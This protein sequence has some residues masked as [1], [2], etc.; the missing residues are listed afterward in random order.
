MRLKLKLSSKPLRIKDQQNIFARLINST[1]NKC[2][3]QELSGENYCSYK[4]NNNENI[5]MININ[6]YSILDYNTTNKEKNKIKRAIRSASLIKTRNKIKKEEIKPPNLIHSVKHIHQIVSMIEKKFNSLNDTSKD[7]ICNTYYF[8]SNFNLSNQLTRNSLTIKK[9]KIFTEKS[10]NDLKKNNELI[11][12][13]FKRLQNKIRKYFALSK[14]KQKSIK[15]PEEQINNFSSENKCFLKIR[16]INNEQKFLEKN[17]EICDRYLNKINIYKRRN[18]FKKD[19]SVSTENFLFRR[20]YFENKKSN[21]L[22]NN[23][24]LAYITSSENNFF[25]TT[26]DKTRKNESNRSILVYHKNY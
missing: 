9:R 18:I 6:N 10:Q 23:K 24:L 7:N 11:P 4:N 2:T 19:K 22:F 26:D 13:P 17:N 16:R 14:K 20:N 25:L 12:Y 3:H 8:S 5:N 15:L 1:K 21:S